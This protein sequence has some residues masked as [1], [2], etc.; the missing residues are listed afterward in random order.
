MNYE[1]NDEI[2]DGIIEAFD[3]KLS[4]E[5]I[6]T[7][8]RMVIESYYAGRAGRTSMVSFT[9]SVRVAEQRNSKHA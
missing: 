7:L 3:N 5:Q 6:Y 9:G 2:L 8:A 1:N 4:K